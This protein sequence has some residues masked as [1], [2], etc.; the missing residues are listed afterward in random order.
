MRKPR[1]D[2][3]VYALIRGLP[4]AEQDKL[5][6]RIW[7]PWLEHVFPVLVKLARELARRKPSLSDAPFDAA[8]AEAFVRATAMYEQRAKKKR[9]R[10][11]SLA[12]LARNEEIIRLRK[13]TTPRWV[14]GG[15]VV[16]FGSGNAKP[17]RQPG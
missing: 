11:P 5:A 17:R 9:D 2:E 6:V 10:Q 3:E 12:N 14:P 13:H 16:F 15:V 8:L 1:T 4:R 7:K